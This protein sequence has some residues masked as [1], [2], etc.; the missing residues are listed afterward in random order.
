MAGRGLGVPASDRPVFQGLA[1]DWVTVLEDL[2]PGAVDRGDRAA[3][4]IGAH[5][6]APARER[7][8]R[9]TGDLISA[10]ASALDGDG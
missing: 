10:M 8:R 3:A 7:A 2:R 9:P 4:E 6:G 1:R 5:L